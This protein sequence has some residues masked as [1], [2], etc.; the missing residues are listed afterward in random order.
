MCIEHLI[1]AVHRDQEGGLVARVAVAAGTGDLR[2]ASGSSSMQF[3]LQSSSAGPA[4]ASPLCCV[5]VHG[6]RPV[7]LMPCPTCPACAHRLRCDVGAA[8]VGGHG[9]AQG[10]AKEEHA[11][12]PGQLVHW[13]VLCLAPAAGRGAQ[14]QQH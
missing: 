9:L 11:V 10:A 8:G 12:M 13:G 7:L 1:E 3:N 4:P 2:E 6:C 5:A 14:Q